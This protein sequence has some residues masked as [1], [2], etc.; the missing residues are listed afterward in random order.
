MLNGDIP[1]FTYPITY[2]AML[3]AKVDD[4]LNRLMLVEI[5]YF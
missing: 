5:E 3:A 1:Q 4:H 2:K